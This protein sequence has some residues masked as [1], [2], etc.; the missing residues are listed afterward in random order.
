MIRDAIATTQPESFYERLIRY[1]ARTA[2][3]MMTAA[4]ATTSVVGAM[5]MVSE[6]K[7]V[8]AGLALGLNV[9]LF[10]SAHPANDERSLQPGHKYPGTARLL[11]WVAC[12]VFSSWLSYVG[13]FKL[14]RT[15]VVAGNQQRAVQT[16]IHEATGK[17]NLLRSDAL[18]HLNAQLPPLDAQIAA[19]NRR[20]EFARRKGLSFSL[21]Q[22]DRLNAQKKQIADAVRK[23]DEMRL[24]DSGKLTGD[25]DAARKEL[26]DAFQ[27]AASV[28]AALPAEFK[29]KNPFP[30]QPLEKPTSTNLQTLAWEQLKD[31]VPFAWFLLYVALALDLIPTLSVRSRTSMRRAP[32]AIRDARL[33]VVELWHSLFRRLSVKTDSIRLLIENYPELDA[34]VNFDAE[35]GTPFLSDL[36][37]HFDTLE[38]EIG[39]IENGV[40]MQIVSVTS[41]SGAELSPDLPLAAQLNEDRVIRLK[42]ESVFNE[43]EIEE[44]EI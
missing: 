29:Q 2:E 37:T 40:A 31:G 24:L 11:V 12:L 3:W 39:E 18:S 36:Q 30:Q 32:T 38:R 35:T 22:S 20:I 7:P 10:A 23:L 41:S 13:F 33:W 16:V 42:L 6:Y 15:E 26:F 25:P 21:K 1:A 27:R 28:Y 8:A 4:S 34:E 17:L 43:V 44:V 9:T 14:Y 5:E 19:E